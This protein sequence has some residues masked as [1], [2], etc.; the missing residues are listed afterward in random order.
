MPGGQL[1]L[2]LKQLRRIVEATPAERSDAEL[3]GRFLQTRDPAAFAALVE[4]HG[5]LVWN[6]CRR[7]LDH[8]HDAEDAFQ[9]TFL[10]LAQQ[11]RAIRQQDSLSSWLYGVAYRIAVRARGRRQ[12]QR[13]RTMPLTSDPVSPPETGWSDL[14]P[15]LDEEVS[16][17]P[18]KYRVPVL[19]CYF[20]GQTHAEAGQTLGWPTGT[21][22]GRLARARDL[23][24]TRLLRRGLTFSAAALGALLIEHAATAGVP[25]L[26][27]QSTIHAAVATSAGVT[28]GATANALALMQGVSKAMLI[29]RLTV[30][31]GV[32][33]A[34]LLMLTGGSA[35]TWYALTP[36]AT[37]ETGVTAA[38]Q[39]P[40][41][42]PKVEP[43]AGDPQRILGSWVRVK[44]ADEKPDVWD[45]LTFT[46]E[47][48]DYHSIQDIQ[49]FSTYTIDQSTQPK[50]MD[51]A[52]AESKPDTTG[53]RSIDPYRC[54][55]KLD[56]DKLE[57]V[58]GTPSQRPKEFAADAKAGFRYFVYQREK[59]AKGKTDEELIL[60]TWELTRLSQAT[61]KLVVD[62]TLVFRD[63]GRGGRHYWIIENGI[64][65]GSYGFT[66][67]ASQS[68]KQLDG[69]ERST[70]LGAVIYA[71]DGDELKIGRP[72]RGGRDY[73]KSWELAE[74]HVDV[75]RRAGKTEHQV[76]PLKHTSAAEVAGIITDLFKNIDGAPKVIADAHTNSLIISAT[77]KQL[78]TIK[79]VIAKLDQLGEKP[80]DKGTPKARELA[81]ERLRVA[82]EGYAVQMAARRAGRASFGDVQP[83]GKR[84][85]DAELEVATTKVQ[86]LEA[87]KRYLAQLVE[88]ETQ[89]KAG[90]QIGALPK[91]ELLEVTYQRLDFELKL[92]QEKAKP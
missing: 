8:D 57:L 49:F 71:I 20:E 56:G 81:Q 44:Q 74:T 36:T 41:L 52:S 87:M 6:V 83:W 13:E 4:R 78:E 27:F 67:D 88:L 28:T 55:Y 31:G 89:A 11:A 38:P 66:L 18:T 9:A 22:A 62:R 82:T 70:G 19:L 33:L 72:R 26:L 10:L 51:I 2:V 14:K 92:E 48:L 80:A 64:E 79:E 29:Q 76:L 40:K 42:G 35:G 34:A 12:V 39:E 24:R 43:A 86:R 53:L 73:P 54:I 15:I 25:E 30:L 91:S 75:Y 90:H 37:Q 3:L 84:L 7:V 21:V 32:C 85:L 1:T 50:S 65:R 60:G 58:V 16:R 77:A 47:K 17:L 59:E 61:G 23:L 5:R 45:R 68:P 69:S 46:P 63:L